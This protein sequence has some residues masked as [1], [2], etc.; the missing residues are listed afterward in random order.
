MILPGYVCSNACYSASL[1]LGPCAQRRCQRVDWSCVFLLVHFEHPGWASCLKSIAQQGQYPGVSVAVVSL[2]HMPASVSPPC[3]F[4]CQGIP[5]R[6]WL[7]AL[8]VPAALCCGCCGWASTAQCAKMT[9]DVQPG[10]HYLCSSQLCLVMPLP[11]CHPLQRGT[12]L[13][14]SKANV[15]ACH[16]QLPKSRP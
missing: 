5:V 3:A 7:A 8:V 2:L 9:F 14:R 4:T 12:G 11:H 1:R 15:G 6:Q 13:Q 16:S 10:G